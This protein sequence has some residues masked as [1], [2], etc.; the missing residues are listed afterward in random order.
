MSDN[1]FQYNY[2]SLPMQELKQSDK[3]LLQNAIDALN[4]S[5]A[6]YSNFRVGAA[7]RLSDQSIFKGANN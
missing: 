1:H 5:Y 4:L 3:T 6:P 2:E 7:V